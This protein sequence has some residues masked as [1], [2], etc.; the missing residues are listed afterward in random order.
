MSVLSVLGYRTSSLT[1]PP[2]LIPL[3]PGEPITGG[4]IAPP[5]HAGTLS[6]T[7]YSIAVP[8]GATE[9]R[10]DLNGDQDV[11][12]YARYGERVF[13]NGFH[14]ETDYISDSETGVEVITITPSS[15]PALR[16][17]TYCIAV[18]NFGPGDAA[19]TVTA[20]VIGGSNSHAPAI[21][22]LTPMVSGDSLILDYAAIDLDGDLAKAEVTII[23]QSGAPMGST[24][25]IGISGTG[26]R[27]KSQISI[28]GV[29][30]LSSASRVSLVLIDQLGNR[31]AEAVVALTQ[32]SSGGMVLSS[33]S[34][35]GSRLTLRTIG[36]AENLQV[37]INGQVVAPPRGIKIK[38]S[39]GKLVVK[40]NQNQLGVH[41]GDN[42][43]RVKNTNGWSNVFIL[44][45]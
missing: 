14:A 25:V 15:S 36:V 19:Y 39:G 40:G 45:L 32:G 12:L 29:A 33:A 34:F 30:G 4:L 21:F 31:S 41:S 10:I 7:Q 8:A 17:G 18:S 9:L 1:V 26:N 16:A 6:H 38:G 37:E 43:I 3:V 42:R 35:D 23:D 20:T 13:I 27:V 11:D 2:L 5:A 28:N 22:N 24:R 44:N